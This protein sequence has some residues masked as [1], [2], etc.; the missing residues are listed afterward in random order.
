MNLGLEIIGIVLLI[1]GIIFCMLPVIPGQ[2]IAFG[3]LV[4]KYFYETN[5]SDTFSVVMIALLLALVVVTILDYVA[6]VW[7]VKKSGGSKHGSRGALIGMIVGIVLTPIGML[8]GMFLGA[9]FGEM[10]VNSN[11]VGRAL[12]IAAMTFL[13]F[14]LSTGLK[15]IYAFVCVWVFFVL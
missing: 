3:A 7:V 4:L 11:N 2:V 5:R 1:I 6:P 8:L 13:G 12:R 9:F 14:L 15:L 10:L